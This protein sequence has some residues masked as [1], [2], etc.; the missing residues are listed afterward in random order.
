MFGKETKG[1][2]PNLL[3]RNSERCV[4]IPQLGPVRSLNL[5]TSVAVALYE[6][7]RQIQTEH[8]PNA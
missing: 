6:G 8:L 7:V 3:R 4:T 5:A 2:S 1:L